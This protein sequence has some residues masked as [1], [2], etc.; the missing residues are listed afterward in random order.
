MIMELLYLKKDIILINSNNL[1][2]SPLYK[3]FNYKFYNKYNLNKKYFQKINYPKNYFY[4]DQYNTK[5]NAIIN[6][7]SKKN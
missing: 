4:F 1:N 5:W 7:Y 2:Y 3:Y 6:E